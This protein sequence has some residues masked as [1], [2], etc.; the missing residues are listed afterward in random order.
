MYYYYLRFL[1]TVKTTSCNTSNTYQNDELCYTFVSETKTWAAAQITCH[2][3][4]GYLAEIKTED[5]NR[6]VESIIFEHPGHRVWLGATDLFSEGKWLWMTSAT[7]VSEA[8]TY[9]NPRQPDGKDGENCMEFNDDASFRHW[10]DK[11]CDAKL[12]FLCQTSIKTA[13]VGR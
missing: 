3:I 4:G 6:Y 8:F 5:Q 11:S 12:S 2:A 9:W 10:N 7:L 13:V 1:I